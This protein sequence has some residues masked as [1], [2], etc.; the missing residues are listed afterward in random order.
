[1]QK[2]FTYIP[3]REPFKIDFS[4]ILGDMLVPRRVSPTH[5]YLIKSIDQV[6]YKSNSKHLKWL[7]MERN[8]IPYFGS[9]RCSRFFR[10][11][12]ENPSFRKDLKSISRGVRSV[13]SFLQWWSWMT[14]IRPYLKPQ[15]RSL[16]MIYVD[17]RSTVTLKI[18]KNRVFSRFFSSK[19]FCLMGNILPTFMQ[20][21]CACAVRWASG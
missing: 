3:S 8:M 10:A 6:A 15:C 9:S 4:G 5:A 20:S 11:K 18:R 7:P 12:N 1:M 17:N 16:C 14:T 21:S 19:K 2:A 13:Q